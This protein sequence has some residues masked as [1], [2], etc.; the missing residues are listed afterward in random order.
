MS[1]VYS[2]FLRSMEL[3]RIDDEHSLIAR[4]AARLATTKA[5]STSM[6]LVQKADQSIGSIESFNSSIDYRTHQD[7]IDELETSNRQIMEEIDQLRQ[8]KENYDSSSNLL[9]ELQ[10]LK[11]HRDE[12][13][14]RMSKLHDGRKDLMEQLER[15]MAMLKTRDKSG[16][17]IQPQGSISPRLSLSSCSSPTH[18]NLPNGATSPNLLPYQHSISSHS[19]PSTTTSRTKRQFNEL[20]DAAEAINDALAQLVGEVTDDEPHKVQRQAGP[21]IPCPSKSAQC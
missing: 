18:N 5:D 4:Y 2:L 16:I 8:A 14:N 20:F 19:S 7:L 17:R 10:M 12:L 15:L 11:Q 13:E 9:L 3:A 1:F 6:K 21:L